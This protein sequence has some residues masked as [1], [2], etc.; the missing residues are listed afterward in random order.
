MAGRQGLPSQ[1]SSGERNVP[2]L[3]WK[4]ELVVAVRI[5]VG[6]LAIA[7]DDQAGLALGR[8]ATTGASPGSSAAFAMSSWQAAIPSMAANRTVVPII[9]RTSLNIFIVSTFY[10]PTISG[11]VREKEI[12]LFKECAGSVIFARRPECK[13]GTCGVQGTQLAVISVC[14][15]RIAGSSPA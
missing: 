7:L 9:G 11:G 14:A 3:A 4:A 12:C 15:R 10:S 5:G 8:V 6:Q 13:L 2:F 1:P